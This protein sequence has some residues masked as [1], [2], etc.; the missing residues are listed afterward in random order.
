MTCVH[1]LEGSFSTPDKLEDLVVRLDPVFFCQT[2]KSFAIHWTFAGKYEKNTIRMRN[3]V[4]IP[5]SRRY[6]AAV[7]RSFVAY[8]ARQSALEVKAP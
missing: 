6:A 5:V 1:T 4:D 7:R 2:H 8:A 3:G